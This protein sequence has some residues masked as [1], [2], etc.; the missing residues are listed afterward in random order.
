MWRNHY[1]PLPRAEELTEESLTRRSALAG[2][3]WRE[4]EQLDFLRSLA[5][6]INEFNRQRPEL[7]QPNGSY[8][9]LDAAVLY[10]T[11]RT[12]RPRR[13]IEVGA[14]Y[15]TR[16]IAA[17]VAANRDSCVAT[18]F[19]SFDPYPS[20]P[21]VPP[22]RGLDR[23]ERLTAQAIPIDRFGELTAGDLLFIDTTHVVR[24]GGDVNRLVLDVLPGLHYGVLVHFHDIFLPW[25]YPAPWIRKQAFYWTEQ[26]LVQAFLA[27]NSRFRVLL[28]NHWVW[29]EH[30]S[31][32]HEMGAN[33][34]IMPGGLW[35]EAID[36]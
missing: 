17:A 32:L 26:Y 33:A 12:R 31:L 13:I 6:M 28:S 24:T 20:A 10:A 34:S 3:D 4:E 18:E 27:F 30:R 14:G 1:S 2:V 7:Q 5:P 25:E 22:P 16:V 36:S 23:V 35:V 8:E 15:S 11:V 29:R 21:V 19:S 9:G